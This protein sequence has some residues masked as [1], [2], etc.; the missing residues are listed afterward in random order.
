M[1]PEALV[2]Q[3]SPIITV[4]YFMQV[5]L[6]LAIVVAL[7]Y[8][9]AKFVLPRMQIAAPGRVIQVVDR[10]ML[11]P[12]V[13]AYILKVGKS[14]WLVV[15]SSKQVARIDKIEPESLPL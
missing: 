2:L 12:Q 11:E 5:L 8:L 4:G 13:S 9:I 1:T 6:S 7:I 3:S 14:A 10:I 15:A